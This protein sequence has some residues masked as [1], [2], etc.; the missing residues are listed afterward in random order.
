MTD[1]APDEPVSLHPEHLL[2]DLV[3]GT[4]AHEDRGA[5]EDHLAGCAR[6]RDELDLAR[7]GASAARSLG[8]PDVPFGLL[9]DIESLVG[10]G[11]T[12]RTPVWTRFVAAVAAVAMILG[13]IATVVSMRDDVAV[14]ATAGGSAE[15]SDG[16]MRAD[17]P[18][19][20]EA[21][22]LPVVDATPE[23]LQELADITARSVAG[24]AVAQILAT[25]IPATPEVACVV[26]ERGPDGLVPQ[27]VLMASWNGAPAHVGSFVVLAQDRPI[28]ALVVVAD[29]TTCTE[30]VS[31]YSPL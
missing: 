12:R 28:G 26:A 31:Y 7:A 25:A 8:M 16:A 6:C 11:M 5:L 2:A 13:G 15:G 23:A 27:Q 4:L 9:V 21:A 24:M 14:V 22:P 29:P 19:L 20:T 3:S 17:A 18:A 1:H 10:G 30:I